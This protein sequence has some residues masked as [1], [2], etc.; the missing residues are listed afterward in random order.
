[1]FTSLLVLNKFR[2]HFWYQAQ[3]CYRGLWM[4]V[5][6]ADRRDLAN[7]HSKQGTI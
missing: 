1:M 3:P 4:C 6:T 2:M 5:T 7:V